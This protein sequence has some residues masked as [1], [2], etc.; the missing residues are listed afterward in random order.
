MHEVSSGA[1]G[2][3]RQVKPGTRSATKE[4]SPFA[5]VV[6]FVSLALAR[7]RYPAA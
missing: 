1:P 5:L 2:E 6:T 7:L 3:K 4:E